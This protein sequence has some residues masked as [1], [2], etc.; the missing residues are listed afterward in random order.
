[1]LRTL[2]TIH[3]PYGIAPCLS[4]HGLGRVFVQKNPFM[5]DGLLKLG[6]WWG[7][8][9]FFSLKKK[10]LLY[11]FIFTILY[12]TL[13]HSF[14]IFLFYDVSITQDKLYPPG[15][16]F[17]VYKMSFSF[18]FQ[19]SFVHYCFLFSLCYFFSTYFFSIRFSFNNNIIH[20][21]YNSYF[22]TILYSTIRTTKQKQIFTKY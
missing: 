20:I 14:F 21:D 12:F 5:V 10:I 11:L 4:G 3:I 2:P 13:Y 22:Y 1:M 18:L 6:G 19:F 15:Q 9:S 8:V 7:K 17:W 16:G